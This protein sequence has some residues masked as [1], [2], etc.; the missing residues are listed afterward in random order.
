MSE[1]NFKIDLI[2]GASAITFSFIIKLKPDEWLW[3][4]SAV[5]LVLISE[6]LNT[7]IE[8]LA[9]AISLEQNDFIKKAKDISA[10]ASLIACIY[11]LVVAIIIWGP[12]LLKLIN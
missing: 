9:D 7:A 11:S 1:R 8:N 12:H 10:A 5:T 3:I 2:L 4:L 6:A